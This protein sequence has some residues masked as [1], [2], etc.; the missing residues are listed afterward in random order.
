MALPSFFHGFRRSQG[1]HIGLGIA[2]AMLAPGCPED[3]VATTAEAPTSEP[4]AAPAPTSTTTQTPTTHGGSEPTTAA[5][6]T[7]GSETVT[8]PTSGGGGVP[9][10]LGTFLGEPRWVLRDKDDVR[11]EALVE[12]RCGGPALVHP[13]CLP[14]DF[15]S[16][17][18]FPCVRVV[19][20]E[21]RFL[22]LEYELASGQIA[23]CNKAD[24]NSAGWEKTD[25]KDVP[26]IS[27]GNAE[28]EG[29]HYGIYLG[30]G[31]FG[32][33]FTRSRTTYFIAGEVYY[34]GEEDCGTWPIW[35]RDPQ[36]LGCKGPF[37]IGPVCPRHPIPTWAKNLLPNPPY[38]L[39]VE[40]GEKP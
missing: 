31:D 35:A 3:G 14:L 22:N 36:G 11:V 6:S 19:A 29:T 9:P 28:C 33:Q 30:E 17:G 38:T 21:G 15:D 16:Q 10:D 32:S 40:Y 12:P 20:H 39:D 13:K 23:P 4:T 1:R 27:F 37:N 24:S 34:M 26:G 5:T 18:M 25:I 2:T 8:G 7:T